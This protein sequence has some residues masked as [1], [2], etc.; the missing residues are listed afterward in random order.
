MTV[1]LKDP[2]RLW[3]ELRQR[4]VVRSLMVY[5]A[6][7]FALLQAVDMIFPRLGLPAW[8]VTLVIALL[9]A[10]L[11]VVIVLTWIFDITPEGIKRTDEEEEPE[12]ETGSDIKYMIRQDRTASTPPEK[13]ISYGYELLGETATREKTKNRVYNY[14]SVV[15]I[16]AVAVLFTFSSSNTVPFGKR[17]WVVITDF[18]NFTSNPVFDR[19]LYTAFTLSANQSRYINILPRSRMLETLKRMEKD[20]NATV[21][22]E[23]G[24][25]IA[26]REGID[27]FIVP[28]ITSAGKSFSI[29][30]RI[31]ETKTGDLLRSEVVRAEDQDDI[32][33]KLD[34]IAKRLRRHLGESRYLIASQDKP[35]KKVTTSSLEALKLYSAGIDCNLRMDFDGAR[36]YYENALKIDTGFVSAK[37]SLGNLLIERFDR[38]KGTKLLSEAARSVDRLTD[39]ER[40]SILTLYSVNV[41]KNLEKGIEYAKMRIRLYPDDA[42]AR[43]NLGWY[44]LNSGKYREALK[45]Y[46]ETVRIFPDMYLPYGGICWLYLEKFGIVDSALIWSEKMIKDI[47]GNAWGYFYMGSSYLGLDSLSK[48]ESAFQ[49]GYEINQS[50]ML[51]TYRLAHTYRLEGNYEK[52]IEI[53]KKAYERNND[54]TSALYDLGI[55]YASMGNKEE[56]M[57][58]YNRFYNIAAGEWVKIYPGMPETY[59]AIG[60]ISARMGNMEKSQEMLQKA[61][62]MDTSRH[63]RFAELLSLQGKTAE[64]VKEI[65]LALKK[66]Y[67]DI[68]WLKVNPDY[69]AL[70]DV[71]EFKSLLN[72]YFKN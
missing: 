71:P 59:L 55:N 6:G 33:V 36:E 38:E 41:M 54:E 61:I 45:Q 68:V 56:A 14:G 12:M 72:R 63:E 50:I 62:G 1:N 49:K 60:A 46:M 37:A 2:F 8:T 66:G 24:R 70:R 57:K 22:E 34:L 17:D 31:M 9:A 32:L 11:V 58:Y 29:S 30:A 43:N 67:R 20:D 5:I 25:E 53:L 18:E 65:N 35:L 52:A 16:L 44:Y 23:T 40:L 3:E 7:A 10:G 48:A 4:K 69:Q 15:V 19:S 13:P 42:T 27:I 39:R 26:E 47:P 21:D 51:N 28:G 64:A